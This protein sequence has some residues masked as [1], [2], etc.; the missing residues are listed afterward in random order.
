MS[1]PNHPQPP[2]GRPQPPTPPQPPSGQEPPPKNDAPRN[3][4]AELKSAQ[5]ALETERK[6]RVKWESEVAK[7]KQGQMNDAEKAIERAR[8]EGR[9]EASKTA[10]GR[11][12]AAEFRA[13][14]AGKIG[15]PT[16]LL[17]ALDMS[18]FV[19]DTGEPDVKAIDATIDKLA[20]AMPNGKTPPAPQVPAGPREDPKDTDWIREAMAGT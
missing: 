16:A 11:L 13:R 9:A 1:E 14:A 17:E 2:E 5:A 10:G 8:E 20:A 4:E 19:D 18:K 6:S 12:A 15:D 7:L 3:L